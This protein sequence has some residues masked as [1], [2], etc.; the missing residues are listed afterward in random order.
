MITVNIYYSGSNGNARSFA[1][2]MEKSGIADICI[3]K[4]EKVFLIIECKTFGAEFNRELNNML[5]DGGQLFSYWQQEQ[6]CQWIML[7]ASDFD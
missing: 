3:S 2:E 5:A 7:Y 1:E 6:N 4:N